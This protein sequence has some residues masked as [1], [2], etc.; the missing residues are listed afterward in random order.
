MFRQSTLRCIW[1]NPEEPLAHNLL[2][3]YYLSVAN[4]TWI[5]RAVAKNLL[6]CKIEGTFKDAEREFLR[7]HEL[8]NDWLPTGLWLARV[9]LAQKRPLDEV[10]G[11]IDFGLSL[12]SKEPSTEIERLEL[13]DL[14]AKL[15]LCN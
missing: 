6:G 3:R 9:L 10:K 11:W 14:K 8:K 7:A 13:L 15:K 5:E 1:I 12:G 4:L 2:G